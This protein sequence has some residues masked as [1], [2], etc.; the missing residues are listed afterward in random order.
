MAV[1]LSSIMAGCPMNAVT[2]S[3]QSQSS[4]VAS[5]EGSGS[6]LSS[7]DFSIADRSAIGLTAASESGERKVAKSS[8]AA[9]RNT[10]VIPNDSTGIPDKSFY[11]AIL[12]TKV[13]EKEVVDKNNDGVL[14]KSELARLPKTV[15][16]ENQGIQSIQGIEK[17]PIGEIHLNGN[18]ISDISPLARLSETIKTGEDPLTVEL[19]NNRI[20]SVNS[21]GTLLAKQKVVNI[22]SLDLSNN[23]ISDI[24]PLK[25]T[26]IQTLNLSHNK[27][28]KIGA[29]FSDN[30][31]F[32][33]DLSYNL[34]PSLGDCK[35][36]AYHIDLSH[37]KITAIKSLSSTADEL[38][39]SNNELTDISF[40]KGIASPGP[41]KLN[42]SSNKLSALPDIKT[43][44][45]TNLTPERDEK[46]SMFQLKGNSL[47][48]DE[49]RKKLPS[50]FYSDKKW[51]EEQVGK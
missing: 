11:K 22:G 3:S 12:S 49:L 17:L 45:W 48:K 29:F 40:L 36:L 1:S 43:W 26:A 21:F 13:N 25:D 34:I 37:N 46:Q 2:L 42:L 35:L 38:N 19:K 7:E 47:A 51:L 8:S 9:K 14:Q 16:W 18:Q 5:P 10:A 28:S 39:L 24:S 4:L 50:E 6:A 32:Y 20:T 31:S 23:S 41:S 44:A 30:Q 33:L 15:S 27:I